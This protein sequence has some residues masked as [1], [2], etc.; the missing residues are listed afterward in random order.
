MRDG[1]KGD[2]QRPLGVPM[3]K[4]DDAWDQ[5][6]NKSKTKELFKDSVEENKELYQQLTQ[7]EKECGK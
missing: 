7:H 3:D 5:I 4:F 2:R 1:G 6:F